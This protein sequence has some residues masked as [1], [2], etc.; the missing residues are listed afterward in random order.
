[1]EVFNSALKVLASAASS[2]L[3]AI[4]PAQASLINFDGF[5]EG[6]FLTN[7]LVSEG[8]LFDGAYV[9]GGL[10]PSRGSAPNWLSGEIP[11]ASTPGNPTNPEAIS[12][13][14]INPNDPADNATTDRIEILSVFADS[15]TTIRLAAF[16]LNGVLLASVSRVDDGVLRISRAKIHSFTFRHTNSGFN[17]ID[18]VI[19]FDNLSFNAVSLPVPDPDPLPAP[20]PTTTA[21]LALG[22]LS[23]GFARGRV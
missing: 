8:V 21:L 15:D 1:M 12:G 10:S 23:A 5:V 7:Q 14:F 9:H 11:P 2:I 18:D 4:S 3:I 22:L 16:D 13:K 17:G 20:E 19:G 6:T